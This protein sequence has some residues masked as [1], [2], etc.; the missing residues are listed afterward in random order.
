MFI[1]IRIKIVQI[2]QPDRGLV[3]GVFANINTEGL[4]LPLNRFSECL[5]QCAHRQISRA[6][7]AEHLDRISVLVLRLN[8]HIVDINVY[9]GI[10]LYGL[11]DQRTERRLGQGKEH[12][13]AENAREKILC[14]LHTF[15]GSFP[16]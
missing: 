8:L 6:V 13:G 14:F 5:A 4:A 7:V 2:L 9:S 11:S 10:D 16:F 12:Q 3:A 1:A 15:H